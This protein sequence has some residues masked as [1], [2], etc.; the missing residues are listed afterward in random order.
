MDC[1]AHIIQHRKKNQSAHC[2]KSWF[3]V[4]LTDMCVF[5]V[6]MQLGCLQSSSILPVCFPPARGFPTLSSFVRIC[7]HP[8]IPLCFS[9][10]VKRSLIVEWHSNFG[11][12]QKSEKQRSLLSKKVTKWWSSAPA[13]SPFTGPWAA[14][15]PPKA[16]KVPALCLSPPLNPLRKMRSEAPRRLPPTSPTASSCVQGCPARFRPT[17]T[18]CPNPAFRFP[19]NR[20][21]STPWRRSCSWVVF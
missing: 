19:E 1:F 17:P 13:R 12:Q 6:H 16:A 9:L 11:N 3:T 2:E 14:P 21:W 20:S 4:H 18:S 10:N 8:K 5:K 7:V 15:T